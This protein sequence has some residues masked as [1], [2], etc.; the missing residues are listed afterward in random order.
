M[1]MF[2][3]MSA[4][5]ARRSAL[6]ASSS[7]RVARLAVR[8]SAPDAPAT[9]PPVPPARTRSTENAPE[10]VPEPQ[11][12]GKSVLQPELRRYLDAYKSQPLE[13]GYAVPAEDIEVRTRP[14]LLLK[15]T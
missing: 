11:D 13:R 1:P 6:R 10:F 9:A 7:H 4:G 3:G 12:I 14:Q 2:Q 5:P 15:V 8:V